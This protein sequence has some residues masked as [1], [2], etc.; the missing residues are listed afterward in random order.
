MNSSRL[1]MHRI[2][3]FFMARIR[4]NQ[5][6]SPE[7]AR[8]SGPEISTNQEDYKPKIDKS[9]EDLYIQNLISIA[10]VSSDSIWIWSYEREQIRKDG[11]GERVDR[12]RFKLKKKLTVICCVYGCGFAGDS[13]VMKV[14]LID[15]IKWRS[16]VSRLGR[17]SVFAGA[18]LSLVMYRSVSEASIVEPVKNPSN[19]H[20]PQRRTSLI[21]SDSKPKIEIGH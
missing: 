9:S 8:G 4:H 5:W 14:G 16:H 15:Q 10:Q 20:K 3:P 1:L 11:N 13:K 6:I 19:S 18:A 12:N 2:T 7:W 17:S 21:W